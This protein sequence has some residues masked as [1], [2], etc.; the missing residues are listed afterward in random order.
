MAD[1]LTLTVKTALDWLFNE[2]LDLSTMSDSYKREYNVTWTEGTGTSGT[3]SKLWH[4]QRQVA[5]SGSETLDLS[6]L[7]STWYGKSVSYNFSYVTLIAIVNLN[8]TSADD[9]YI[10]PTIS[11]AFIYPWSNATKVEIPADSFLIVTNHT[12]RWTVG[13]DVN[14]KLANDSAN[15]VDYK[16]LIAG[17]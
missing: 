2:S 16:I 10:D 4:D 5:G 1:T 9:L 3:A 14:L 13:T 6:A 12:D 7:A 17:A 11:D 15:A 8:T